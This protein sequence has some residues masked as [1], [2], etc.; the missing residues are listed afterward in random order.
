MLPEEKDLKTVEKIAGDINK[1][2]EKLKS[3]IDDK[4]DLT[5]LETR[6]D[7]ITKKMEK[8]VDK[9]GK[10]ILSEQLT[11][12]QTQLDEISTQLK[13]LGEYQDSKGKG[14][15]KQFFEQAK[16]KEFQEKVKNHS[17]RGELAS[18]NIKMSD[19]YLFAKKKAANID[20]DDIN[21]G[22][23]E[24]QTETGVSAAPWRNS[25]LWDNINK[26]VIGQGHDSISW[27]DE[28]SRTDS[29]DMVA[30]NAAPVAGSAATWTKQSM[31]IKMIKD[32]TKVSK[33][34]L[35]DFEGLTSL[36]NDLITN[37]IPRKRETELL[38][39]IGTGVHLKGIDQYARTFAKPANFDLVPS[40]NS[41]DV[42]AAAILQV[43]NGNTADVNKKGFLP[44]VIL[45]NPGD[46]TNMLELKS[47]TE[48]I[49][50]RHP[51]LSQDGTSFRGLNFIETL[52][53]EPGEF[54]V[55]DFSRAKAWIKRM[56][57]ISFHYDNEDDALNDLVLVLASMRIAGLQIST[58][59]TYAFVTGTFDA[60]KALITQV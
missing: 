22:V 49:Y 16:S 13:Q 54:I 28:T 27:W 38:E 45:V 55:G 34:A 4:A 35:E 57:N 53:L 39:G 21:A 5:V 6:Y 8:L 51:M 25:P 37:G 43:N 60:G 30:E 46:K 19:A 31:D 17:G 29:A 12:Q 18:I 50:I 33:S 1:A 32:Y 52:D 48:H 47:A 24:T 20:T 58:P 26:G 9:D 41:G 11:K 2:I 42:L 23:I 44:N 59:D 36:V 15:L 7:E 10:V 40:A 56:M 3:S 14:M